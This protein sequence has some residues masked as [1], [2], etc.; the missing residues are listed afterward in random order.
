MK[1]LALDSLRSK[2]DFQYTRIRHFSND[3]LSIVIKKSELQGHYNPKTHILVECEDDNQ[4]LEFQAFLRGLTSFFYYN[5]LIL[6]IY[7][8]FEFS[9][10][11]VCLFLHTSYY[12]EV[13]FDENN[14]ND[15]IGNCNKYIRKT[16]LTGKSDRQ[17]N[18]FWE[19]ITQVQKLR[20]LLTHQN[21]NLVKQKN[22]VSA[23]PN[24]KQFAKDKRL[25][26]AANGQVYIDDDEY[27]RSF[28]KNTQ[29]YL[30]KV[31]ELEKQK[32]LDRN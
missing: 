16:V 11:Q 3:V 25:F 30:N 4:F 22:D 13:T 5:S 17:I 23:H 24:Y 19:E 27:I 8:L 32:Q 26:I 2:I 12:P 14:K 18:I 28:L 7:S 1:R 10:K 29:L 20:N 15:I 6:S 9:F 21:G 31:I